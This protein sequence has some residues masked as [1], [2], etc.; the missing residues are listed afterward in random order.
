MVTCTLS[1]KYRYSGLSSDE[2]PIDDSVRESSTYWEE[3][4]GRMWEFRG[5]RWLETKTFLDVNDNY[6]MV[7]Y[8]SDDWL[9]VCRAT[10]GTL[11]SDPAWQIRRIN[12][13]ALILMWAHGKPTFTNPATSLPIVA[14]LPYS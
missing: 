7:V 14:A 8:S 2:K 10:P 12:I 5:G 13:D 9:W 4:T 6:S 11:L 3:D 1:T